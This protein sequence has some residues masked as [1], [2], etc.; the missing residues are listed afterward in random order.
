MLQ[1]LSTIFT[2]GLPV[3]II[4]IGIFLTFRLLDFADMTAEGSFLI[5]AAV[6]VVSINNGINPFIATFFAFLSGLCCG[7]VTGIINRFLKVPKLLSGIITMTACGGIVYFIF[8]Y[9]DL[10]ETFRGTVTLGDNPTIYS[11]FYDLHLPID[12][13]F[14]EILVMLV[15]VVAVMFFIYFFFGTEYG[16]AI[17]ATGMNEKTARAQ[18]I[19]TSLSTIVCI[20]LSNGLIALGASLVYQE[21]GEVRLG[22]ESGRLVI[23][24][25]AV[26]IGEAIFGKRSFKN[27]LIS[28]ALGAIVYYVI[29]TIAL[30]VG[31]DRVKA[32]M[33]SI[34]KLIYALLILIALCLPF[35][36]KGFANLFNKIRKKN[37]QESEAKYRCQ[38]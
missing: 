35:I 4:A 32:A 23:G 21:G 8:G 22:I 28:V 7:A 30:N 29:I 15:Y 38:N 27:W 1:I 34:K 2:Q 11:V 24:L 33:D 37:K 6:T 31:N 16:M 13:Y 18:G 5:S 12:N 25:A 3:C 9:S 10:L 36:K 26:L 19:N 20:A 14:M 17:R